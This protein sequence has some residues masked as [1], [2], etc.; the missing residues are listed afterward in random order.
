MAATARTLEFTAEDVAS[1]GGSGD[2]E[3]LEV[4]GDYVALLADV[5][6]YDNS[7]KGGSRGWRFNYKV[8]G[9]DFSVFCAFSK[10]AR[11]KLIEVLEAH[12]YPVEEGIAECDPNMFVGT[13]VGAHVDFPK[14]YYEAL[15]NGVTPDKVYREIRWVFRLPSDTPPVTVTSEEPDIL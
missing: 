10:A 4:P 14:S 11:W 8:E 12:G 2:Y 1:A 6:D 7:E 15:K 9:L 5:V 13:E 3:N